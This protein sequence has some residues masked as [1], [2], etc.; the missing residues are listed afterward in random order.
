M[1]EQELFLFYETTKP[2]N[3]ELT[4]DIRPNSQI[5]RYQ[6]QVYRNQQMYT[7]F[8][9]SSNAISSV[10]LEEEGTYQIVVT[11]EKRNGKKEIVSSGFYQI[12]L[13]SPVITLTEETIK[14][15]KGANF[16]PMDFVSAQDT[17]DGDLTHAI[18]TNYEDLNLVP[19]THTLT[20]TV[21]DQA[22]NVATRSMKIEI[23]EKQSSLFLIQG[24]LILIFLF[25][26]FLFFRYRRSLKLEKRLLPYTIVSLKDTSPSLT[27]KILSAYIAILRR[28]NSFLNKSVFLTKYS[29]RYDKYIKTFSDRYEK[30]ID[31]VSEK[32]IMAL[33]CLLIALFS[34]AV[35]FQMLTSYEIVFP[36]LF[37]F[38]APDIVYISQYK[39]YRSR[40]ENDLLQAIIIMNNAFKSGRSI[41]QAVDLVKNELEGPIAEE[42][43]KMYMEMSFGLDIDTVFERFASRVKLEEVTYLT[44]SLS[45]LNKTGGN[46]IKVFSSIEKSLFNKKKLKLELL[47]LTGS[48]RIIV[49]VLFLV[50]FLFILFISLVSPGYFMPFFSSPIGI[51]LV[52]FMVVYYI[53][54][55]FFVRKIMKVRM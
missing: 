53:I 46:I 12:D 3:K 32:C 13:T 44:A 34:K 6:Y 49:W 52:L 25:S 31:F 51:C 1:G 40:I 38:F 4:I 35:Q 5:R 7:E 29:L 19:G 2:V 30:G 14:M 33:F 20:Y 36:L 21:E 54:Y 26:L 28:V 27:E 37:G 15:E 42:F 18:S 50:P 48:S 55:V 41:I 17:F 10:L 45:I 47:S 39:L 22:G 24:S 43:K 16:S 8:S 23:F 9:S 11:L